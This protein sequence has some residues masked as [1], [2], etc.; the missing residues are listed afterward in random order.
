MKS[1]SIILL[2]LLLSLWAAFCLF[3]VNNIL[4]TKVL[5]T[6]EYTYSQIFVF[7]LLVSALLNYSKIHR[8]EGETEEERHE[9]LFYSIIFKFT[10]YTIFLGMGWILSLIIL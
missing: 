6:P 2:S 4:F 1:F 5:N 7:L 10:Y 9:V 8:E 3:I